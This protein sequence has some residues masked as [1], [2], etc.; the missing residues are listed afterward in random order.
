MANRRINLAEM[1]FE[2]IKGNLIAF[3]KAQ[4]S[5]VSDYNYK[6]S[7][8]NTIMDMLAY[9]THANAVNANMALNE[10]FLDTAQLRASVVSHAKLLGYTPRSTRSA[11]AIVDIQVTGIVEAGEPQWNIINNGT[12]NIAQ[13]LTLKFGTN[14]TT[15]FNGITHNLIVGETVTAAPVGDSW[16]FYNVPLVQGNIENKSYIYDETNKE[17]YFCYDSN[18]DTNYLTVDVRT[19]NTSN[20]KIT[21]TKSTNIVN[22]LADSKVFFLE[23]S[24][25]GFYEILFGDDIIGEKLSLGN[26]IE[27]SY[28]VTGTENI[29]GA[30]TFLLNSIKDGAGNSNTA[31]SIRTVEAAQGGITREGLNSIKYNAP[32]AYIAQNRAVTPDDYKAIIQNEYGN[33]HTMAVW[34]GEDNNPPDFGKVYISIKPTGNAANLTLEQKAEVIKLIKPKNVV[35]IQPKL[36]DPN[37]IDINITVSFK[38][39]PNVTNLSGIAIAE[40]IRS[41]IDAYDANSL[42][43][44]GGIFRHSNVLRAIDDSDVSIMSSVAN[45]SISKD[46]SA[47]FNEALNYKIDFNQRIIDID[48]GSRIT[49]T[50]FLYNGVVCKLKD[51]LNTAEGKCIIQI[52]N[53][54]NQVV[55]PNVGYIDLGIGCVYLDQFAPTGLLANMQGN[56]ITIYTKT[57][58]PDIKPLRND[59]L[60]INVSGSSITPYIDNIVTGGAAAGVN[61]TTIPSASTTG[62]SY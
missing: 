12:I 14:V 4:D 11:V 18:I 21:F 42:Q 27:V 57:E 52:V 8:V 51:Y 31:V 1:D 56:T 33:I 29:N 20:E 48:P 19:S 60:R 23:E 38:Y 9:I 30:K 39:D 6:G 16:F 36:I 53:T 47:S 10:A 41:V 54:G 37:Y 49:S 50:K 17:R 34:G 40:K 13:D 7:A 46:F 43:L 45:V 24:R 59:L 35:S 22:V 2:G 28:I 61:Y 32:R 44:F 62:G 25:E 15:Q 5:A 3:M 58:S 55:N 26:I